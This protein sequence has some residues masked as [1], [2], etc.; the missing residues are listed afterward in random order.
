MYIDG[1]RLH[2]FVTIADLGSL[3]RAA[4]VLHIA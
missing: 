3:G 4:Q 1:R 2:Y